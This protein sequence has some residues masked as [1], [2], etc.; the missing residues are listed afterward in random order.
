M[1]AL[2]NVEL[3]LI[4]IDGILINRILILAGDSLVGLSCLRE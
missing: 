3:Y 4:R 2:L 1:R